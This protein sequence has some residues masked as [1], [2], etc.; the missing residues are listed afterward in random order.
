MYSR[1]E[2]IQKELDRLKDQLDEEVYQSCVVRLNEY[3]WDKDTFDLIEYVTWF[4]DECPF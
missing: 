4:R 2:I 1:K 3:G